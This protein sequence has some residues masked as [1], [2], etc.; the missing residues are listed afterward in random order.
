[1]RLH[2]TSSCGGVQAKIARR[3]AKGGWPQGSLV[4]VRSLHSADVKRRRPTRGTL[5]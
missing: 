4:P 3:R 2:W 5:L 1:M